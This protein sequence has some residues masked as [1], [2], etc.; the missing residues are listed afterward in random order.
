MKCRSKYRKGAMHVSE[1]LVE[2][3]RGNLVESVHFG[4]LAVVDASGRLLYS[5]GSPEEKVAFIRSSSKPIQAIP[6]VQSGAVDHFGLTEQEM[7][8]FC[9][10]HSAEQVHI[11]AVLSILQKIGLPQGALQCGRHMPF[12]KTMSQ[13]LILSGEEPSEVHCNC[14]GKHSGML[15]LAQ[16]MGWDISDYLAVEHPVQ[17][18]MRA[19]M[20]QFA[21]LEPDQIEIGVDGCGAPVF[22]LSVY[23]MARSWAQLV[24]PSRLP[25]DTQSAA[26]RITAAMTAY[27][28]M[29]AGSGRLC[30]NLMTHLN[31]RVVAKSGAE[32]VYCIGLLN[33][34]IGLAVKI[35]DGNG[36]AT[37]PAMIEALRQ[38]GELTDADLENLAN[39]YRPPLYNHRRDTIGES[40]PV[41]KLRAH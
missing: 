7:A 27:P 15:T 17:Q 9:A 34:G 23:H 32:G 33:K 10:S 37:G 14:S 6:V 5:V 20:A 26:Q 30:T 18:A 1:R 28:Q 29:V 8:V 39:H 35:Q 11:D 21:G 19:A 25:E 2:L 40:R 3:T 24:D 41:F 36:R 13:Q 12:D 38:M 22:G 4:D 16:H 31:G